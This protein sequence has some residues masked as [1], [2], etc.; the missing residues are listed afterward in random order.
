[1][2]VLN[3]TSLSI[4]R[5]FL[6]SILVFLGGGGCNNVSELV[7]TYLLKGFDEGTLEDEQLTIYIY[8]NII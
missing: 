7:Q 4:I 6:V 5:G 3:R 1:M 2:I 8:I